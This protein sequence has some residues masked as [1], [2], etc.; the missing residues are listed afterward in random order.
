MDNSS[1]SRIYTQRRI[2]RLDELSTMIRLTRRIITIARNDPSACPYLYT[3]GLSDELW[4]FAQARPRR[5]IHLQY[6][7]G[8]YVLKKRY[9]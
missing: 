9:V 3:D 4:F 2:I 6:K 8:Q 5:M 1:Y 7:S